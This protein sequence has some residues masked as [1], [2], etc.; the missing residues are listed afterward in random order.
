MS[1]LV[2]V[3]VTFADAAEAERIG[4]T[5]VDEKLAACINILGPTTS[6]YRWDGRLETASET[7]AILKT[8]ASHADALVARLAALHSY[9]V[10]AIVVWPIAQAHPP[11]AEWVA[12][13]LKVL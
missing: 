1:G 7:A 10:P 11:Y 4:R 12:G 5:V 8:A 6:I 2:S 3:Y 9:Q 13:Q